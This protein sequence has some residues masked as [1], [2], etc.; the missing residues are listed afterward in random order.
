VSA[1]DEI[2]IQKAI[3][4]VGSF[5]SDGRVREPADKKKKKR[6]YE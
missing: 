4:E 3:G 6:S 5:P 2:V 1:N